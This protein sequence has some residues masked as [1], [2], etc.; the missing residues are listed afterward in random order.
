MA[1]P[2]GGMIAST[3][4]PSEQHTI[5]VNQPYVAP[6][7]VVMSFGE[8]PVQAACPFCQAQILTNVEY[9]AGLLT[10]LVCV[11]LAIFG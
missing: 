11:M 5:I 2:P 4:A 6:S 1:A 8:S 10:W 7:V 9:E 3:G